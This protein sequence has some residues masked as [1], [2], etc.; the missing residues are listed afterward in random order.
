MNFPEEIPELEAELARVN[1][2]VDEDEVKVVKSEEP[3]ARIFLSST[4]KIRSDL[5]RLLRVAKAERAHEVIRLRLHGVHSTTGAVPLRALIKF[6]QP[7]NAVL[8]QSAWRIWDRTGDSARVD[9]RFVRE[10]D[11]RLAAIAAGSTELVILGNTAPDLTGVSALESALRDIFDLLTSEVESFAD[12]VH[13][14][15]IGAG[16]SLSKFLT[17]LEREN[18]T[19]HLEWTGPDRSHRWDGCRSEVVRVRALLDEIGEPVTTRERFVA[20]VNVISVRNRVEIQ[21][22]DTDAK[23]HVAY[24]RSLAENVHELRLGEKRVFEIEKTV[25]PFVVSN[26]KRDAYRLIHIGDSAEIIS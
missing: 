4:R 16:R 19:A 17:S 2:M 6:V 21:L 13:A 7:L 25:Y 1:G 15:G 22:S 8:E 9:E 12:R 26:R 14:I 24:H 10:L 5:Q 20:T 23:L 18:V 3:S 11:L